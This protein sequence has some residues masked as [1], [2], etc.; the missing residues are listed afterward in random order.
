[1]FADDINLS[2]EYKDLKILFSLVNEELHKNNEWSETNKLS[3]TFGKTKYSLF[4]KPS[5]KRWSSS[6]LPRLLIK[7]HK[8]ER[9][10]SKKF[11]GVLVDEKLSLKDH[12]K[13]I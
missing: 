2:F 11:L 7:A 12:I 8:I 1:M 9:V 13:Y 4:H 3:L 6:L 5:R 10:K